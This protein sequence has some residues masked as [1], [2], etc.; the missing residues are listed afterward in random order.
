MAS[1]VAFL[2]EL[3]NLLVTCFLMI[4]WCLQVPIHN[5]RVHD[6]AILFNSTTTTSCKI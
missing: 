3:K 6:S 4:Q 5:G 1:L 2:Y